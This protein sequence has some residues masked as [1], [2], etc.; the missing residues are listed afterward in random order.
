MKSTPIS[1]TRSQALSLSLGLRLILAV[2]LLLAGVVLGS[3]TSASATSRAGT[4]AAATVVPGCSAFR[5]A[6]SLGAS[7]SD[8]HVR[9][10][11][12]GQRPS[13]DGARSGGGA[14]VHPYAGSPIY[15][16]GYQCVEL[17]A[18]YL[19]ARFDAEPGKANGAQIVDRYASVYPS[20][21]VRIGNGTRN[22][23]PRKGDV[24]SLSANR[25]FDDVGHT[26]I[27]ASSRVNARGNGTVRAVEQN[28]GG[29]G[30]ASG[31]HSYRVRHWRVIFPGLPHIEWLRSR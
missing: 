12:C 31:H 5:G 13:F 17:V 23:A 15:Y 8:A 16:L 24:M 4:R 7:Y 19:K 20:K 28:W 3:T 2:A 10:Y 11:A 26:G 18:R 6:R 22:Q 29:R 25:Y 9:V 14:V 1:R 30:G 21:F 27:V